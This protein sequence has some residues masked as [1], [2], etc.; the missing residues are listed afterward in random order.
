MKF[1]VKIG[2]TQFN[3]L[4]EAQKYA[5]TGVGIPVGNILLKFTSDLHSA[6]FSD[7]NF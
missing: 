2:I 6:N 7:K 4:Q 1:L 5:S 3:I